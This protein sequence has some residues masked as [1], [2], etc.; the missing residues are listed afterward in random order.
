MLKVQTLELTNLEPRYQLK[1]KTLKMVHVNLSQGT[2]LSS[3]L[4]ESYPD[5]LC[6]R[7]NKPKIILE[8]ESFE[9]LDGLDYPSWINRLLNVKA[10]FILT[11]KL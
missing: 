6:H 3:R 10:I 11:G 9:P 2:S 1:S 7:K 5:K 4:L 8:V